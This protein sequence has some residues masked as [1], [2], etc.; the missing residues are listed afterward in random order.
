MQ[1][2]AAALLTAAC[3]A[4]LVEAPDLELCADMATINDRC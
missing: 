4:T 2:F 3:L 1:S